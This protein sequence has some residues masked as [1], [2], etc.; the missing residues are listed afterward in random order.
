M[1]HYLRITLS[2]MDA[3]FFID[4]SVKLLGR[5]SENSHPFLSTQLNC[6][7]GR[8]GIFEWAQNRP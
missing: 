7:K 1:E 4:R 8:L 5:R 6:R 2:L 3:N